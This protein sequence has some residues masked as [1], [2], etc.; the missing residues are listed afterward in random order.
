MHWML[1]EY[2]CASTC[3]L[4]VCA[5]KNGRFLNL[6]ERRNFKQQAA[7]PTLLL[8]LLLLHLYV[9]SYDSLT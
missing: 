3:H 2:C 4:Y 7:V 8:L 1:I 9:H 5:V 6:N